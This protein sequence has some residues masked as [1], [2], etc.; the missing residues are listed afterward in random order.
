M[1]F[2][3][4]LC[5]L[6]KPVADSKD[7]TLTFDHE[8]HDDMELWVDPAN[9]DKIIMNLLSNAV[10]YT[11]NGGKIDIKLTSGT[12]DNTTGPLHQ[13][14]EISVTDTGIGI[15]ESERQH[16][17]KRFYQVRNNQTGGTG[18]GLHLTS[19]LIKLH[20]GTINIEDNP[21]G[22]G[23]RFVV[24]IPLGHEHLPVNQ[25]NIPM[26][27]SSVPKH[28]T[29]M[30]LVPDIN[31]T[32]ND[33]V[34]VKVSERVL[35]VEDDEEIRNYVAH[36]LSTHYKVDTCANGKEALDIIF[37]QQPDL[38]ISDVMMPEM[39]GLELTRR[40][41]KN[42][43]LNHIPVVLLTAKSREEDNLEGLE[44]GADAYLTKPF[45]IDI[46][47]KTVNNLLKSH[48]RLRNTF[49]GNQ[50]HDEKVDDIDTTSSDDKLMERIM[51][52]LNKNLGNPDITVETL[53]NEIGISRVH[54]HRKLKELTN[55]SPRDFIRNTR[56][57]KAAK[58]LVEKKLTVAE[59]A[60][61]TGFRNP[62]NFATSFKELFGVSPTVYMEQHPDSPEE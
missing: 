33:N 55:Q 34:K 36:E 53:A 49:S 62:N 20:Y 15:P 50:T 35:V 41:K 7:I 28:T 38:V 2:I 25:L 44:T 1:P 58:L 11:P 17:F 39:D 3:D 37:K 27:Q 60:D 59:V 18:V 6:F 42:I 22:Q 19:S 52:V 32:D 54:L 16:I 13:Y 12:D 40:I 9:F 46:L 56:L 45:N 24:R 31:E 29:S 5:D 30:V 14:A 43:N 4:D 61:L 10:K 48:Q 47:I 51:K 57:R 23:T 21:E 26:A 8:G